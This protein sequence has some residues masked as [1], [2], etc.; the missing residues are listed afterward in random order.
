M[1]RKN[2]VRKSAAVRPRRTK[3]GEIDKASWEWQ[4]IVPAVELSEPYGLPNVQESR[5]SF[6]DLSRER[7]DQSP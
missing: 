3:D 7:S 4:N 2:G 6:R 5:G 1:S